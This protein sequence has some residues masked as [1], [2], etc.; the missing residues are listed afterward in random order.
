M[1]GY[2]MFFWMDLAT[3]V[4]DIFDPD[5][6]DWDRVLGWKVS[7]TECPTDIDPRVP[8]L[9]FDDLPAF[10]PQTFTC[11]SAVVGRCARADVD[12]IASHILLH[13][14]VPRCQARQ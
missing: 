1:S 3:T 6:K 2:R 11:A 4:S 8:S 12:V 13:C 10:R 14:E 5:F 9:P 7:K